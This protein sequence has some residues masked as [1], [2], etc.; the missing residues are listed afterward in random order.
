MQNMVSIFQ[1][2]MKKDPTRVVREERDGG[3]CSCT[4]GKGFCHHQLAVLY[5]LCHY[6]ALQLQKIPEVVSK[7][8]RP[9]EWHIPPRTH[10]FEPIPVP[11]LVIQKP[12][13]PSA[14]TGELK[15]KNNFQAIKSNLYNPVTVPLAEL[16]IKEKLWPTLSSGQVPSTQWSQIWS[17]GEEAPMVNSSY[18]MVPKGSVLSYQ[19]PATKEVRRVGPAE[20]PP[21]TLPELPPYAINLACSQNQLDHVASLGVTEEE[22]TEYEAHTRQQGQCPE[23]YKLR[24]CRLTASNF[25]RVTGRRSNHQQLALDLFNKSVKKT[26]AMEFGTENET[27][28]AETYAESFGFD[29]HEVG[30]IINPT[31]PYLGCSP[32]RRVYDPADDGTWGLLEVKCS[33]KDSIQD[34]PFFRTNDDANLEL[35]HSHRYYEQIMGQMGLT[36]APWC[37]FFVWTQNDFHRERIH[38]DHTFFMNMLEKLDDF[39]FRYFLPVS[40]S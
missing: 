30:F 15:K 37:D 18:G 8:S 33:T 23:W 36:G 22:A 3:G 14:D 10:G 21:L 31:R 17:Q 13:Q 1:I 2:Y 26:P 35:R 5:Q 20:P 19:C 11:E 4:A 16:Q 39:Y 7:T 29:I 25:K 32:D 34:L 9:Q 6:Q 27:Y 12:P 24:K 28:A 38:Y 40:L